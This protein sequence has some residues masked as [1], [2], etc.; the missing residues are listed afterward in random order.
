[1]YYLD[2]TY[3]G[4]DYDGGTTGGDNFGLDDYE[5]QFF[6]PKA[7]WEGLGT[8][9]VKLTI[10]DTTYTEDLF[11]FCHIHDGMSG[12]IKVVDSNGDAVNDDDAPELGYDYEV[13]SPF[14]SGCG[15]YGISDY[16]DGM[17]KCSDTFICEDGTESITAF[18]ECIKAMNCDMEVNMRATLHDDNAAATFMWQ[19]IPHHRNAVNMAK[20]LLKEGTLE[21][22]D[23]NSGTL[24]LLKF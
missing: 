20:A 23:E 4:G 24:R 18:G 17:G 14:D 22:E 5:P 9:E 2:G 21:C 13:P 12:R 19:M 8:F 11:Y 3:L 16:Q 10:T 7:D 1:M 15:T 6:V